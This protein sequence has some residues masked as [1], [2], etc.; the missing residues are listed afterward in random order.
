MP[1]AET[2]NRCC[3]G[4]TSF[5]VAFLVGVTTAV[6]ILRRDGNF[7]QLIRFIPA[8]KPYEE[9]AIARIALSKKV[10]SVDGSCMFPRGLRR[11][12][13]KVCSNRG[14]LFIDS[15]ARNT[16]LVTLPYGKLRYVTTHVTVIL[17]PLK[18]T[19]NDACHEHLESSSIDSIS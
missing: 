4:Y 12:A 11:Y 18:V 5:V 8:R 19:G 10:S 7:S 2:E 14:F 16:T 13:K 9:V 15:R 17:S 1:L 6:Q 3:L